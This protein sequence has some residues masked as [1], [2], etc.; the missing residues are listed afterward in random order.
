MTNNLVVL[1]PFPFS[2]MHIIKVRPALCLTNEIGD[3]QHIVI[4]FISS[5]IPEPILESDFVIRK[6]SFEGNDTGLAVDSV[7]RL[8]KLTSIPKKFISRKLGRINDDTSR[9][10]KSKLK[11]MF[12]C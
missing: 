12:H 7:M 1:V 3:H 6:N 5:K 4:A 11:T 10:I 9:L 2:D 8:H